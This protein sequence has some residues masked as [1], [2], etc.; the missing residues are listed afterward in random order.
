MKS[1]TRSV[2]TEVQSLS[3]NAQERYHCSHSRRS[4][5]EIQ[6]P[7]KVCVGWLKAENYQPRGELKDR[8][9]RKVH[10]VVRI[11]YLEVFEGCCKE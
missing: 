8:C 1:S 9:C 6:E 2:L 10:R 5:G 7:C 4:A 11:K 3:L